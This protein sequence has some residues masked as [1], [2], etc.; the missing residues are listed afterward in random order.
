[1]RMT[2]SQIKTKVGDRIQEV[3][4]TYLTKVEGWI[5]QV[6]DDILRRYR[7]PELIKTTTF[8]ATADT[9]VALL[10]KDVDNIIEIH[11]RVNDRSLFPKMPEYA[12]RTSVDVQ[13]VSGIPHAYW[14]EEDTVAAQPSS[15]SVLTFSSSASGDTTQ[16]CRIWGISGG[17]VTTESIT[18]SGTNTV[19]SGNSYTRVDRISKSAATSGVITV[20]SNSAAVTV[21]TIAQRD[22]T[23]LQTKI[24]FIQ[25]PQSAL[26]YNLI[27][28]VKVPLLEFDEDIPIIACDLALITGAYAQGLEEQRQFAKA[29][30]E[31]GK[32]QANIDWLIAEKEQQRDVVPVFVPH[33]E[34]AEI[35]LPK[36]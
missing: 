9:E 22:I 21:V 19:T 5:N 25:R 3:D 27:Y 20:T 35:D 1:M 12:S 8:S 7:W 34:N 28:R 29:Q 33:R 17:E 13:D 15:A 30:V 32:F 14:L 18:L 24:H 26:T 4:S 2:L 10:P 31:W 11:D 16:T 6:Y 23:S 36:Q